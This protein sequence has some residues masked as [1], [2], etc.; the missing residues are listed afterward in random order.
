MQAEQKAPLM[1]Y[2]DL[3]GTKRAE[4]AEVAGPASYVTGGQTINASDMGF[5]GFDWVDAGGQSY[6][7]TYYGRISYLPVSAPP[8]A[9]NPACKQVKLQ[10]IV[11]ATGAEAAAAVNLSGE[12]MR[13]I[14]IAPV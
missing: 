6:S 7:G 13:M 9:Q 5:G 12:I 4:I 11:T 3:W 2:P 10:W 1:G 14:V 8:S